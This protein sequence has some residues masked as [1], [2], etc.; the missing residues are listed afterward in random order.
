M[1]RVVTSVTIS[2]ILGSSIAGAQPLQCPGGIVNVGDTEE[3]V[4]AACGPP[5]S[6]QQWDQARTEAIDY[7]DGGYAEP[8]VVYPEK[9][10]IYNYGPT[11][12][13]SIVRFQGQRVSD[14]LQNTFG[15]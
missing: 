12:F 11:R 4:L 1:R 6:V 9:E 13:I 3:S 10:W 5:T 2:A 7:P 14:I 15:Y 8:L